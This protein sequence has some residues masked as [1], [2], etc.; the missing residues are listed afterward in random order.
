MPAD[1]PFC[2]TSNHLD[3]RKKAFTGATDSGRKIQEGSSKSSFL[4][5]FHKSKNLKIIKPYK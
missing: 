2:G 4:I 3:I 1:G 5:S